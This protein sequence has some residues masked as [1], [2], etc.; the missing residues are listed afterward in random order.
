MGDAVR[1]LVKKEPFSKESDPNWSKKLYKIDSIEGERI[2]NVMDQVFY[3]L[4]PPGNK[5]EYLQ[6]ELLLVRK[7]SAAGEPGAAASSGG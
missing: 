4:S 7:G 6:H 5:P 1:T 2:S 3:K